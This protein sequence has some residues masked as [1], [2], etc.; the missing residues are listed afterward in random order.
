MA[1]RTETRPT[2]PP[3]ARYYEALVEV[4]CDLCRTTTTQGVRYADGT[5][6]VREDWA[7]GNFDVDEI[8]VA[9]R[10]GA[11]YPEGGSDTTIAYDVCPMCWE[12]K[13]APW[14]AAQGAT[15]HT[16]EGGF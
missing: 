7:R 2:P 5:E 4:R 14:F 6:G 1:R 11:H 9:R 13:V 16:K 8:T 3:T 15:P 12:T 10:V